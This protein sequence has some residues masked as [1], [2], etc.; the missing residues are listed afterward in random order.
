[1][2]KFKV[3]IEIDSWSLD[4]FHFFFIK[5]ILVLWVEFLFYVSFLCVGFQF[6]I[7]DDITTKGVIRT[8]A[9]RIFET[10]IMFKFC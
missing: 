8:I 3:L 2:F 4:F 5:Y 10:Q 1:M 7:T 9:F 6:R